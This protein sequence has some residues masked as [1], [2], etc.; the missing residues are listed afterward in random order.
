MY[1]Q[2]H[3]FRVEV[4]VNYNHKSMNFIIRACLLILPLGLLSCSGSL[5]TYSHKDPQIDLS[6]YKSYAWVAAPGDS[7]LNAERKDKVYGN[8]IVHSA[9]AELQ[10]KGMTRNVNSPDAL[11]VFE[12]K[13]EEKVKYGRAAPASVDPGYVGA[14]GYYYV[15]D[16][17]PVRGGEIMPTEYDEGLLYFNMYDTKTGKRI[18]SGGATRVLTSSDNDNIE[19]IIKTAVKNILKELPIKHKTK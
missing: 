6:P 18:W 8:L 2:T 19:Q 16:Q 14:Y 1:L 5:K 10:K 11:F 15:G 3:K 4:G 9:D 17:A 7:V 12:S 13:V